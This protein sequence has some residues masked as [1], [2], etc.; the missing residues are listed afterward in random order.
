MPTKKGFLKARPPDYVDL[1][2]ATRSIVKALQKS[3]IENRL[4]RPLPAKT[5]R[6][7]KKALSEVDLETPVETQ[8][9]KTIITAN[10]T[11]LPK[12]KY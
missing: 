6:L 4:E 7:L 11:P 12:D 5:L 2:D 10:R 1:E 3:I 8:S 9:D